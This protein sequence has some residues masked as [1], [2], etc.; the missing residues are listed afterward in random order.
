MLVLL[1]VLLDLIGL[2]LHDRIVPVFFIT[3]MI[4]TAAIGVYTFFIP[5]HQKTGK[6]TRALR[7]VLI[8][9]YPLMALVM[10][11]SE[12]TTRN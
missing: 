2:W 5:L 9:S 6:L 3:A 4:E 1:T 11:V 8:A 7:C 12:T 10:L